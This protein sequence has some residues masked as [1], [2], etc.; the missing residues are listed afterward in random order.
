MATATNLNLS[1][2]GLG[3]HGLP[4]EAPPPPVSRTRNR[5]TVLA[6]DL[7]HRDTL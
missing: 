3:L 4:Q 2:F 5:C 1:R 6:G 7:E